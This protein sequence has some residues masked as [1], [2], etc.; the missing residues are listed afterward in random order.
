[1][2]SVIHVEHTRHFGLKIWRSILLWK[3]IYHDRYLIVSSQTVR[4]PQKQLQ[5]VMKC[6]SNVKMFSLSSTW[7]VYL[8]VIGYFKVKQRLI[9]DTLFSQWSIRIMI[10]QENSSFISSWGNNLNQAYIFVF[11]WMFWLGVSLC[12]SYVLQRNYLWLDCFMNC[13]S[14]RLNV[15]LEFIKH[16]M[17]KT[18]QVW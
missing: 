17:K 8:L 2:S 1:M 7:I 6:L 15:Q 18:L 3:F 5:C 10:Y 11:Q 12:L 16:L 4:S 9:S 13:S 14:L